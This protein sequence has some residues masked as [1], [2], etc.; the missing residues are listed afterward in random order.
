MPDVGRF[1]VWCTADELSPD[2]AGEVERL[3]YGTIWVGRADGD[4]RLVERLLAATRTVTVATGIVNIWRYPVES[5]AAAYHRVDR[6]HP[7]RLLL[8]VGVGHPETNGDRYRG[9]YTALCR[10][11]DDLDAAGVPADHRV[12]AALGPKALRLSAERAAGAH[13]YLVPVDHTRAARAALGATALLAPEQRVVLDTDA[14]RARAAARAAVSGPLSRAN[15]ARNMRRLGRDL[16][17]RPPTD[18]LLD[19]LAPHGDAPTVAAALA[20]HLRAGAD[21]VAVHLVSGEDRLPGYAA[22]AA[23]LFPVRP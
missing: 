4:L 6:R 7:G 12:L 20:E 3:G 5:V 19:L 17:G 9:P 15:Y 8:G 10:Y 16:A 13:P 2:L 14:D 18:E 1:G 23:E 22:I 11:L 21:H